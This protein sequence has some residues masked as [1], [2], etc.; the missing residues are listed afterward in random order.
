MKLPKLHEAEDD[1]ATSVKRPRHG[2]VGRLQDEFGRVS[3]CESEM[4]CIRGELRMTV[5]AASTAAES[6]VLV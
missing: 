1:V 3:C 2:P 6:A 4:T 5:A